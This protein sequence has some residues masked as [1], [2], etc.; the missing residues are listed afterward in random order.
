MPLELLTSAIAITVVAP[1]LSAIGVFFV[2]LQLWIGRQVRSDPLVQDRLQL[3]LSDGEVAW[4]LHSDAPRLWPRAPLIHAAMAGIVV[5]AAETGLFASGSGVQSLWYRAGSIGAAIILPAPFIAAWLLRG[6]LD[7]YIDRVIMQ[8]A[9]AN[10]ASTLPTLVEIG[11]IAGQI[12]AV[13]ES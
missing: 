8:L 12:D 2:S 3:R 10:L 11:S 1:L 13:Y 5:A 7:R 4:S 6:T 9:N